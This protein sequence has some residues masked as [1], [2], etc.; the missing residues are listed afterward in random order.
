MESP[1]R[2]NVSIFT[3]KCN[4]LASI[5][6]IYFVSEPTRKKT[7]QNHDFIKDESTLYQKTIITEN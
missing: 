2:R 3:R 6:F 1:N 7:N 5:L 4:K